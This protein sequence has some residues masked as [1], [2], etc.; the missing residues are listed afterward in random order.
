MKVLHVI[1]SYEPAWA[2]GGPVTATSQ[3]CRALARQGMD[4]TVYTTNADGKGGHLDVPL[5]EPV[6]LGGVKVWYFRCD[7]GVKRAFYSRSLAN[8]LKETIKDFALVH[9]SAIW[10]WHQV[11]VYRN[12]KAFSKPYIVSI[13]GSLSPW[14][15]KQSSA[16]KRLYW[17]LFGR[18]TIK[19]ATAVHFTAEGERLKALSAVPFLTKIPNFIVPNGIVIKKG[20]DIRESLN[21][22]SEKFVLLFVGRIHRKKGIHFVLEALKKLNDKRF[23]FLIV[24]QR[25]DAD[26]TNR[27]IKLSSELQD[28]VIWHEQVSGDEVWDYYSSSNLFVLPS[29]DENFGMVVVEAMA[30]G[31]PVLVSKNVD[32][33]REVQADAAGFVVDQDSDKIACILKKLINDIQLLGQVSENARKSAEKRYNIDKVASL[34]IKAYEDVLTGRRTRELQWK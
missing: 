9:V 30:C 3:L 22:P 8:R 31:L 20:K 23:L 24:G 32:I 33:W 2:F 14:S 17:R 28:S 29:Y 26:Y 19:N 6:D 11:N 34:M 7:F 21:I 18:G 5:N 16:K 15:W 10:Q 25:E 4:V 13:R 12:C 1:P 27:L